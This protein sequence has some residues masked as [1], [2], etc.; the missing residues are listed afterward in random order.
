M[1]KAADERTSVEVNHIEVASGRR[2]TGADAS[3]G[4]RATCV[5]GGLPPGGVRRAEAATPMPHSEA[6]EA[7]AR[8]VA[9]LFAAALLILFGIM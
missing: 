8:V 2:L 3:G 7:S 4:A 6:S 1:V 9:V 5:R